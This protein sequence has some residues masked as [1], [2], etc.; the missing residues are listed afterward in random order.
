MARQGCVLT[1][2]EVQRIVTLLSS[3]DMTLDDIATR[4]G[5]S[6]STVASVNRQYQ[7]RD[8]AGLRSRWLQKSEV[9]EEVSS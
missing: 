4:M 5:R 1:E 6:R 7:V 3:T 9:A 2:Y 8:Y